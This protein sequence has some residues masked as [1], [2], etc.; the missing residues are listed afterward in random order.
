MFY[1]KS[2]IHDVHFTHIARFNFRQHRSREEGCVQL[3]DTCLV[4]MYLIMLQSFLNV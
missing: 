1:A 2:L 3:F 4:I